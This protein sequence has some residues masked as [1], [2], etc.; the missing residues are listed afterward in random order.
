MTMDARSRRGERE[1]KEVGCVWEGGWVSARDLVHQQFPGANL[2]WILI[3]T[4]W[5][6]IPKFVS[7]AVSGHPK[8]L[9]DIL[10]QQLKTMMEKHE[11]TV[12]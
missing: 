12:C 7:T 9:R 10:L 3:H 2:F 5:I 1:R 4:R 8:F 11:C 6:V